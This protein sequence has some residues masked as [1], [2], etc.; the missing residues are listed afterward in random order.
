MAHYSI[1]IPK[2]Q[3][4]NPALLE[5]VGLP[6]LVRDG[7]LSPSIFTILNSGP[8]GGSGLIF[9]WIEP[10]NEENGPKPGHYPE[11]QKWESAPPDPVKNLPAGR[12]WFGFE[13]KRPPTPED[14]ARREQL[15]GFHGVFADGSEWRLPS[16]MLLPHRYT[17]GS[18]GHEKKV[19]KDQ[20]QEIY[21]RMEWCYEQAEAYVRDDAIRNPTEWR[22]YVAFMLMQNYRI[23]LPICYWLQLFDESNWWGTALNTVDYQALEQIEEDLKKKEPADTPPT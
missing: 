6:G 17:L 4:P 21:K 22:E 11:V 13:P 15:P 23:N 3:A 20:Y 9:A 5:E 7:D 14:L 2:A 8:D 10:G 19:I 18:D 12:Y 1:Y 16:S